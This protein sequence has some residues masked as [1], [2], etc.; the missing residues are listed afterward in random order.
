[1]T[2]FKEMD[3]NIQDQTSPS[4]DIY[5]SQALGAPTT[6]TAPTVVGLNYDLEVVDATL[7]IPTIGDV[8]GTWVGVFSGTG[9]YYWGIVLAKVGNVLTMDTPIDFAFQIGDNVLPTNRNM[10]EVDGS[11]TPQIFKIQAGTSGLEID[12]TR[13]MVAMIAS[14]K[15]EIDLFGDM[16]RLPRGIVLRVV[17]GTGTRNLWNV[18]SNYGLGIQTYD[19]QIYE[20]ISTQGL[21]GLL[22]RNSYAG[23]AKHGVVIRLGPGEELQLVIQDLLTL[24]VL[25]MMAQGHEVE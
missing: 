18:K 25:L 20:E 8:D 23:P 11:V 24:E 21:N 7:F 4:A 16:P 19:L 9:R 5:F 1:M 3:V 15:V 13:I 2:N 17:K 10:G 12:V 22:A 14:T 6:L